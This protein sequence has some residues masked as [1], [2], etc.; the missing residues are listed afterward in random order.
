MVPILDSGH[1]HP[2]FI[3]HVEEL[4][5][6]ADW[7]VF[8]SINQRLFEFIAKYLDL[9]HILQT[10][11]K[12]INSE[13]Y[14]N[15]SNHIPGSLQM[16]IN[17]HKIND[18]RRLNQY[19]IKVNEILVQGGVFICCG[20]TKSERRNRIFKRYSPYLGVFVYLIDFMIRRVMPKIPIVQGWYFALTK[21]KNR[22]ISET[23][24]IGR[25]YFCGFD[26][27][28]KDE[29]DSRM[30][31]ILK[32]VKEPSQDPNP[33]YGPIIKLKRKGKDGKIIYISKLRTMHPYSEYLQDYVY[34][35]CNLQD[36]G[37][38]CDDFRVTV[39][40]KVFRSLWIDELPQILNFLRGE[41]TLVGVRAL[42]EHYFNLYP[43]DLQELR[44]KTK[45]GLVP[46][47]YA[48]MPITFDEIVQSERTY[49][50]SKLKNPF[51]TD[52]KYF[53]KAF[54]NIIFNHARSK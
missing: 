37:K 41:I 51:A 52:C 53:W 18:F 10:K 31:F 35:T 17:L 39:W 54:C 2:S 11:T 8:L 44:C 27:I 46:P 20:E 13:L 33:S 15:I 19:I 24:M 22:A 3:N 6:Q 25:F 30:Y 12:A 1:Y 49:L 45:P 34:R 5:H 16:F 7:L 14:S 48:D 47:F 40:G 4:S 28:G 38:F 50:E 32:K 43:K 42:S 21:G 29:I 26:L 36:G 23:E 9:P